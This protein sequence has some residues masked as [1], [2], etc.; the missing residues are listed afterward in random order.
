[1]TFNMDQYT[2]LYVVEIVCLHGVLVSIVSNRDSRFA[3]TF[4]KRLRRAIGTQLNFSI[5]CH[6]QIDSQSK[7]TI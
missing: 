6:S 3:S 7:R 4:W 1:M 5:T 2:Q